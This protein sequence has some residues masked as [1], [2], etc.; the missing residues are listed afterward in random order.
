MC[1][2]ALLSLTQWIRARGWV[3]DPA[4]TL[5]LGWMPN[6]A[7]GL[8]MPLILAGIL[9]ANGRDGARA[10]AAPRVTGVVAFTTTGLL[11]WELFQ[12]RSP[13]FVFDWYDV[14]ATLAGSAL[15][16][17]LCRRLRARSDRP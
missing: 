11:A 6:F 1:G 3:L 14:A 8:A 15:A 17:V 12:T 7:A 2:L 10:L 13:R 16:A 4:L 9:A 5:V